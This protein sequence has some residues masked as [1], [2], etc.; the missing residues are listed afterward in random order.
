MV[1]NR[2]GGLLSG[3]VLKATVRLI[4]GISTPKVASKLQL[5]FSEVPL[6]LNFLLVSEYTVKITKLFYNSFQCT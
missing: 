1:S 4:S 6:V 5:L 2:E 3:F